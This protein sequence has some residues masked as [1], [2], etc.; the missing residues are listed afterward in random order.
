M[1]RSVRIVGI[2]DDVDHIS[3]ID[4]Y[5]LLSVFS[6]IVFFVYAVSCG[7]QG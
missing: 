6:L 2:R 1:M 3:F 5:L 4:T 7:V